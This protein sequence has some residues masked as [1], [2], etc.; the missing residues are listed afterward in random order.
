MVGT[1]A[2][3]ERNSKLV[4]YRD[5]PGG[6]NKVLWNDVALKFKLSVARAKEIY[7]REKRK[8]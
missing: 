1:K 4:K 7:S 3:T 5:N 8:V 2:K 6:K